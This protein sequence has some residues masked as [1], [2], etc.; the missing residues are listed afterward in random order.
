[1]IFPF[2]DQDPS[3]FASVPVV[4]TGSRLAALYR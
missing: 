4:I 1:L 2:P 3:L